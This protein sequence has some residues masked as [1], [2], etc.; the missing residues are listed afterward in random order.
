MDRMKAQRDKRNAETYR[1]KGRRQE[2]QSNHCDG[3]H[4]RTIF[5]GGQCYLR[6]KVGHLFV[7]LAVALR[8]RV[9]KLYSP[10]Q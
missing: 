4:G 1:D 10:C 3:L 7:D 8:Y 2:G 9:G 5:S 6:A